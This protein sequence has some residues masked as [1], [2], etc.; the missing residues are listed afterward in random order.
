MV[1]LLYGAKTSY[2]SIFSYAYEGS[3]A[4]KV[5]KKNIQCQR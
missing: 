3:R 2:S 5:H 4:W 1:V